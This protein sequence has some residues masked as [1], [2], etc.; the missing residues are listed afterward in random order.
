MFLSASD[1]VEIEEGL[2]TLFAQY[3]GSVRLTQ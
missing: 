2:A 1:P 3:L